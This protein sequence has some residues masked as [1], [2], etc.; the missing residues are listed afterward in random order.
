MHQV[1]QTKG[2]KRKLLIQ[3]IQDL[4]KVNMSRMQEIVQTSKSQL[5]E[6]QIRH[7]ELKEME[8][9]QSQIANM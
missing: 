3:K 9:L 5:E 8:M 2:K 7:T 6:E 1:V 4:N